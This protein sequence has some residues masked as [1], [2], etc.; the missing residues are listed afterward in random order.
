MNTLFI[1]DFRFGLDTRKSELTQKPGSLE[2]LNNGFINQGGEI[3][4][5]KA[6]V[7]TARIA[8]SFGLQATAAGLYTFGSDD[9]SGSHPVNIGT[10]GIPIYVNFQRLRHPAVLFDVAGYNNTLHDMSAVTFST[11]F[12][13][14][15]V[16]A[17]RF[18]DGNV[19]VY[20]DGELIRDFTDG[21]LMA[22]LN[23]NTKIATEIKNMINRAG[24]YTATSVSNVVTITGPLGSVY[25][26]S[27][28]K[29]GEESVDITALVGSTP[30][31]PAPANPATGSFRITGGSAAAGTNK[32]TKVEV[33]SVLVRPTTHRAR[34]NATS[35][36]T[37]TLPSGHGIT[38][39]MILDVFGIPGY[40]VVGATVLT[41]GATTITYT[42]AGLDEA[43]TAD[44]TGSVRAG[45]PFDILGAAVDWETSNEYTAS[46]VA[47]QINTN[48][49]NPE[50]TAVAT[51]NL[52]TIKAAA[53]A[54][55]TPNGY[56]VKVTT[57]G[58]VCIGDA[59]FR[60]IGTG[61]TINSF[62]VDGAD[63][64]TASS[65]VFP[66]TYLTINN[67][68]AAIAADI[69]SGTTTGL[70]HGI[71]AYNSGPLLSISRQVT[72][73]KDAPLDVYVVIA[74]GF[75]PGSGV[76]YIDGGIVSIPTLGV[77]VKPR[78]VAPKGGYPFNL[79]YGYEFEADVNGGTAPYTYTWLL[80]MPTDGAFAKGNL[81]EEVSYG[82]TD[83]T[84]EPITA[85]VTVTD[86]LGSVATSP[87]ITVYS[88]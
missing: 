5:R 59:V 25:D 37:L 20:Y 32:I 9:L 12:R 51:D 49:T 62:N 26:I 80:A 17:A 41:A 53:S 57:A 64:L 27:A 29:N 75:V 11:Q 18:D 88:S 69:N 76:T 8:G 52:V 77:T 28:V 15:A 40:N 60:F 65:F 73:S 7:R 71:V 84:N 10:V 86:S 78:K 35:I 47:L 21:L 6:F 3:E 24:R 70:A 19:F 82:R 45:T 67:L 55:D 44:S 43:T 63:I 72:S 1:K 46:K 42:N 74:S 34:V 13:G 39:G 2:V 23:T 50:Y 4:N 30:T 61:M 48:T 31:A 38:A 85:T 79:P 66:G 83:H 58:N 33:Q 22:H 56:E 87:V 14:K 16:V 36:A 68:V 81:T 54:G